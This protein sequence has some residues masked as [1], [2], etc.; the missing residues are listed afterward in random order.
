MREKGYK[1]SEA[2]KSIKEEPPT[3]KESLTP[4]T[5][6]KSKEHPMIEETQKQYKERT[7]RIQ[8]AFERA[9]GQALAEAQTEDEAAKKRVSELRP[10]RKKVKDA[11]AYGAEGLSQLEEELK[12]V[13]VEIEIEEE[14]GTT[15]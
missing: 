9:W 1:P 5:M 15:K 12:N 7:E 13:G 10:L 8:T 4:R 3:G 2:E 6:E 14:A 11:V